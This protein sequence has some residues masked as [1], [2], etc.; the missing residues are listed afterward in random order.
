MRL[1]HIFFSIGVITAALSPLSAHAITGGI[2][3]D[4]AKISI[5]IGRGQSIERSITVTNNSANTITI[6]PELK[7]FT[8]TQDNQIRWYLADILNPDRS[9]NWI[10]INTKSFQLKSGASGIVPFK[11]HIEDNA[12]PGGR[13]GTIF[14]VTS[15]DK[16]SEE[17]RVGTLVIANIV[18]AVS[19]TGSI[20]NFIAPRLILGSSV[21][22]TVAYTNTGATHY[23]TKADIT[24]KNIFWNSGSTTSD[25]KFI[26]PGVSRV[27]TAHWQQALL[28]GVY[29]AQASVLDGSGVVHT[30]T[31]HFVAIS[32]PLF[33]LVIIICVCGVWYYRRRISKRLV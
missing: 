12:K 23:E 4:P 7:D 1:N 32:Y 24:V 11:I 16:K 19:K 9:S 13:Y 15:S 28:L 22:F 26:Y 29:T 10:S 33:A 3:V 18:G 2:L 8:V 25:Q 21:D 17:M 6:V 5:D 20:V 31:K 30:A 27:L 14:F